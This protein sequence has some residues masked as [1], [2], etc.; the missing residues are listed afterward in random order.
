MAKSNPTKTPKSA[1]KAPQTKG[2]AKQAA[3]QEASAKSRASVGTKPPAHPEAASQKAKAVF[4]KGYGSLR[5]MLKI[6]PRVD[7]SK[8]IAA[9]VAR[10]KV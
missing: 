4:P 7:L 1:R 5:G 2:A 6:D 10:W 9:Q 3:K 8:P